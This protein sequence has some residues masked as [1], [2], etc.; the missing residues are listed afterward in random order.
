MPQ[1][2]P[3][4]QTDR[5]NGASGEGASRGGAGLYATLR[6]IRRHTNDGE[7]RDRDERRSTAARRVEAAGG[8]AIVGGLVR[9]AAP[10]I[11][12]LPIQA[13]AYRAS[14]STTRN[15]RSR[16][17]TSV[18]SDG[19]SLPWGLRE[20]MR[21][22][23]AAAEHAAQ[24]RL[25]Q[26]TLD[27]IGDAIVNTDVAGRVTYLNTIAEALTGWPFGEAIGRPVEEV[28]RIVDAMTRVIVENP[29]VQAALEGK[30]VGLAPN[31]VLIS[32][33]GVESA[34]EDSASAIRDDNGVIAGAVMV[35]RDVSAAR[36]RTQRMEHLVQHDSLTELAN[37]VLLNDRLTQAVALARREQRQVAL[38]FVDIDHFKTVNDT[39]G[40]D[41]GDRLLRS[42]AQR[43]LRCVRT[44][45]TVSRFGGDEFV[46][47]LPEVVQAQD[48]A[49]AAET[50]LR[51][52]DAPH[53]IDQHELKVSL[54]IGIATFP[55]DGDN[56]DLLVRRADL[57]MYRAKASGR[58]TFNF[59]GEA[60][61][62]IGRQRAGDASACRDPMLHLHRTPC[63]ATPA[64]NRVE[65]RQ[66]W[67]QPDAASS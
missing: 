42:V 14:V 24:Q 28:I 50:M 22:D 31:C 6:W 64:I 23:A 20:N 37:R 54:S 3:P 59:T 62:V 36:A 10:A 45:D 57:A 53:S 17:I 52:F 49:L 55:N 33:G 2:R 58:N 32:R 40:H 66:R 35:F 13:S 9:N 44:S 51:M 12:P 5:L 43:L 56:A 48:A 15:E 26:C 38:L 27:S 65:A 8:L 67:C 41:I 7:R 16:D 60:K 1:Y 47:L 46:I 34:I 29:M 21:R 19:R 39:L 4:P 11:A 63:L 30:A 18:C 61:G 25:A